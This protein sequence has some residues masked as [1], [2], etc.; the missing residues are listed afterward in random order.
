MNCLTALRTIVLSL[1]VSGYLIGITVAQA[2]DSDTIVVIVGEK[3]PINSI[4]DRQVRR[5][6]LGKSIKLP[7]GSRAALATYDPVA[8]VFNDQAL[9]RTDAQVNAAWSR[10]KFSGRSLEPKIFNDPKQLVNYIAKQ[11]NAIGYI[12]KANVN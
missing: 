12:A 11:P 1:F 10:L 3:S 6:F 2:S 7:N 4:S 9:K 8:T 5:L